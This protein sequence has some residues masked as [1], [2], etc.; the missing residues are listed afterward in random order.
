MIQN[1]SPVSTRGK[2]IESAAALGAPSIAIAV[3]LRF[4]FSRAFKASQGY[5]IAQEVQAS[6]A[7]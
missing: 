6:V 1:L 3:I 2:P 4:G 5:H 7:L